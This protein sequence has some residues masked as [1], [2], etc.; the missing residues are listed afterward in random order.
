MP[1]PSYRYKFL[2]QQQRLISRQT[3][4]TSWLGIKSSFLSQLVDD[5]FAHHIIL[6]WMMGFTASPQP[7]NGSYLLVNATQAAVFLTTRRKTGGDF[8][9]C[10][11][12]ENPCDAST[13]WTTELHISTAAALPSKPLLSLTYPPL[14]RKVRCSKPAC[15][16]TG[17]LVTPYHMLSL[18]LNLSR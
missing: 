11:K 8:D 18:T 15:L 10:L 9:G 3:Y 4:P 13:H 5:V 7:D 12:N 16:V 6:P 1:C 17:Y 2:S 14:I